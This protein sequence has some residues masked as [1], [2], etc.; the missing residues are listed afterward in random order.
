[1]HWLHSQ[2]ERDCRLSGNTG[3]VADITDAG[4]V[5]LAL[6]SIYN[7]TALVVLTCGVI[8]YRYFVA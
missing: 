6:T 2:L 1:M 3:R 5:L 8:T 7:L 4:G